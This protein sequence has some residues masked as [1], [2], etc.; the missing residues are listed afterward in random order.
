MNKIRIGYVPYSPSFHKPGDCRRFV[1]YA[2]ARGI[3]FE[4]ADPSREYDLVVLSECADLSVWSSYGSGKVVYDL[5]DSYLAI[6]RT[7][8]KGLLRGTAKF[9]SRQSRY[10]RFNHWRAI[11]S[12][13]R[14]AD[15]VVCSTIEQRQD[16]LPFCPNTHV[17]LDV[18]ASVT[19]SIK[20]DYSLASPAR[21]VWEG[22]PY[23]LGS[24]ALIRNALSEVATKI[25]IELH[26]VTDPVYFRYL[27]RYGRRDSLSEARALFPKVYLHEWQESTLAELVCS[28]DVA[29]IPVDLSDPF[30]S[31]KPENKLLLF[32]RMGMPVVTSASPAYVRAMT[33]ASLDLFC[34]DEQ[35]WTENLLRVLTD[36][37][38]RRKAGQQGKAYAEMEYSEARL[39]AAWDAVFESIGISFG[40]R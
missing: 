6:P 4:I 10:P 16:I 2:H 30:S 38:L 8:I 26:L 19:H 18:H 35:Q 36:E 11:R 37:S 39:L 22:L 25:P 23:N 27:G 9:M 7:D 29:I 1:H 17:V 24:L 14:R 32:W 21:L 31:G 34:G 5:I 40:G 33:N 12:M 20:R 15:A 28:C 13:C 3:V